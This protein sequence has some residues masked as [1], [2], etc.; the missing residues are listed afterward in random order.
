[1]RSCFTNSS[2]AAIAIFQQEL[3][4]RHIISFAYCSLC[5]PCGKYNAGAGSIG[6]LSLRKSYSSY[7]K[8]S[9]HRSVLWPASFESTTSSSLF[10]SPNIFGFRHLFRQ[11]PNLQGD[12]PTLRCNTPKMF[13]WLRHVKEQNNSKDFFHPTTHKYSVRTSNGVNRIELE[14]TS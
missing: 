2:T 6:A 5:R 4:R 8:L 9:W 14:G 3:R 1:V 10:S 13:S 11:L 7:S 12:T